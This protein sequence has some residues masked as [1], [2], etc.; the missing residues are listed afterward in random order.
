MT[1]TAAIRMAD[2]IDATAI[3]DLIAAAFHPLDVAQWLIDDDHDRA[4][5]FPEY[6]RILVDHALD[7]GVVHTTADRQAA[8]L[9]LPTIGA[10]APP[11]DYDIRLAA[12]VGPYLQRFLALDTAFAQHHPTPA[13][14]HLALLAVHPDRQGGGLG[15]A[16]LTHHQRRLDTEHM[17]AYLE[18]SSARSRRLYLRHGY[19]DLLAGT[20]HLPA[21]GP[22]LWP[23]WRP[24]SATTGHS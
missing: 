8:A 19:H 11:S 14:H 23:M 22:L 2:H 1:M 18:A 13:H 12:A 10:P 24:P 3:A 20:L 17:P 4:R 15:S 21:G 7:H 9:W 5:I 6:F 16:L